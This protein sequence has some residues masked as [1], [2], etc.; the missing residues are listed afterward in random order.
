MGDYG[1]GFSRL[2]PDA[3]MHARNISALNPNQ[4]YPINDAYMDGAN[5][6]LLNYMA[7]AAN[8]TARS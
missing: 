7:D 4:T 6:W 8:F 2:T 5:V 1:D 3:D